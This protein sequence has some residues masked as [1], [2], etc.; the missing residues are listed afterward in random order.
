MARQVLPIAGAIIGA[1]FGAPQL[2]YAIG[3]IVGNAVDPQVIKGPA[4]GDVAQQTSSEGVYQP[5]LFGTCCCAGN[6]IDQGPNI[7]R[8]VSQGG[9]GG[10]ETQTE[11]LYKSF[12]I[13][14]GRG[15]NGPLAAI[16]RIWEDGKLVYDVRPESTIVA[17]SAKFAEGMRIYLGT[18]DQLPDPELEAIHGVGNVP[19]YVGRAYVVFVKKDITDRRSISDY[20]FECATSAQVVSVDALMLLRPAE[21]RWSAIPSPDGIDWSAPRYADGVIPEDLSQLLSGTDGRYIAYAIAT[22]G[23]KLKYSDD[24]GLT[25]HSPTTGGT[26]VKRGRGASENGVILI[27]ADGGVLRS[28][29]NGVSFNLRTSPG[30][31]NIGMALTNG[32]AV[33]RGSDGRIKYSNDTGDTWSTGPLLGLST[34]AGGDFFGFDGA[35]RF[36]GATMTG[37]GAIS[38]TD[39]ATVTPMA[40]PPGVDEEVQAICG[41]QVG[42]TKLWLAGSQ[43]GKLLRDTGDGWEMSSYAATG[44]IVLI[45]FVGTG[46]LIVDGGLSTYLN[47][48]IFTPDGETF[49][50]VTPPGSGA[51]TGIAANY[52]IGQA[53]GDPI[54]VDQAVLAIHDIVNQPASEVDV[55]DLAGLMMDG[56]VL[57]G[58]YSA[59]SAIRSIG[60]AY[61]FD[62]PQYDGKI[63]HRLRGKPVV[64]TLTIDDLVDVPE[65]ATR[66]QAIEFPRKLNLDYQDAEIDYAPAKE[67]STRSSAD[68]RVVGET[69]F[70]TPITMGRDAAAQLAA[71]LHKVSWADAEGEVKFSVPDSFLWLAPAD[72]VGLALRDTIRRLR[73]EQMEISGGQLNLTCRV[74][75]Q[76]AYASNVTGVPKPPVT[77]PPPSIILPSELALLDI[78][79]L[80][81]AH[82]MGT[83]VIYLAA[84]PTG[85]VW[86]GATVQRSTD[87]GANYSAEAEFSTNT[88]MGVLLADVAQAS[89]HYP[90][91]TN[92]VHMMLDSPDDE[93]DSLTEQQFLSEGGAFAIENGDG[94][95]ELMQYM[96]AA[97]DIDGSYALSHLQRGRLCTG[98]HAHTAGQRVV[99][100]DRVRMATMPISTIGMDVYH[101]AITHGLTAE[102]AVV[103][104][105]VY[106]ARS[107]IE[108]PCANLLGAIDSNTLSL[109]AIPRHRFGTE[110]NPIRSIN[111]TGYRWTATDGANSLAVDSPADAVEFDVTGWST[112]ITATVAQLNRITGAG[113]TISEEFE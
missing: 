43:D 9:K 18:Q 28:I 84:G 68:V 16:T 93:L 25:W 15:W 113:P 89:E 70:Q 71:K 17:E 34:G 37:E 95:W 63:R 62:S 55:T 80:A 91:R 21:D 49:T 23:A 14:I 72:T 57:A 31:T 77:P 26:V 105:E 50:D 99:F 35:V 11:R 32:F 48:L 112:P 107:Q 44:A 8:K 36:C 41:G 88:V 97:Q 10:P 109:T 58:D 3:S 13:R 7:V 4:I 29:D 94:S 6:I 100:L 60:S 82:D 51:F 73:I 65:E 5:I 101:R 90:D 19:A 45:A 24:K 111:W 40:L 59:A 2:G 54:A 102:Q 27:P 1:Y 78:P 108:F 66:E 56:L 30:S 64:A 33:T 92:V 106:T 79:A 86:P 103:D 81:D 110:D 42:A 96:E 75:R 76:S 12:A 53:A 83:P 46:F 38:L 22:A 61:L 104:N 85:D 87:A 98:G 20:K 67:T 39:G 52:S 47:K 74:D 69:N